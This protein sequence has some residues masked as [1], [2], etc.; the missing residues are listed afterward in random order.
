MMSLP[1]NAQLSHFG[2]YVRDLDAMIGFYTRVLGLTLTD[3]G[4]YYRG[5]RIAFLSRNPREHHQVVFA[6][7]RT[8][9]MGA[10]LINQLSFRVDS[11]EDMRRYYAILKV[12]GV[13]I[14]RVTNHGNAWSIYCFDP[15]RNRIEL[16]AGSPWHVGQPFGEPLD[17]TEPAETILAKTHALVVKDPSYAPAESWSRSMTEK[18]SGTAAPGHGKTA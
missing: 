14:D 18:I 7:G 17:L 2:L 1:P 15:E 3:I 9:D 16:Y 8:D 5:G 6:E 12:E 13:P 4:N 10:G 11:L